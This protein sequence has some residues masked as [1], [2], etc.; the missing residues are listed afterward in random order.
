MKNKIVLII[1]IKQSIDINFLLLN[2]FK[3]IIKYVVPFTNMIL[4]HIKTYLNNRE[5]KYW[6]NHAMEKNR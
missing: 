6:A 2:H 1:G 4:I 3:T 5:K